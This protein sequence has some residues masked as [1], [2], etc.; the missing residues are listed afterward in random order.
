[1]QVG[2]IATLTLATLSLIGLAFTARAGEAQGGPFAAAK[3]AAARNQAALRQYTWIQTTQISLKGEVKATK[4]ESVLY[5]PDG[6]QHKTVISAPQPKHEPGI[7]GRIEEREEGELK[8]TLESAALLVQSYVP[9]SPDKLQAAVSAGNMR[10]LTGQPGQAILAFSNYQLPG[11]ALTLTM[12]LE[13]RVIQTLDVSTWLGE[14]DKPVTL[15]VQMQQLPDGTNYPQL[16]TLSIP[17]KNVQVMVNNS[18][19]QKVGM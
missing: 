16:S 19:F 18:D 12:N 15:V 7:R 10:V 3:E 6:Q 17:S 11:D 5:G 1:M 8:S 13:P 14:P 2:R 9:P 4:V